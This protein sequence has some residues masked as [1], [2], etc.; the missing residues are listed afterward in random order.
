MPGRKTL[1]WIGYALAVLNVLVLVRL[2]GLAHFDAQQTVVGV[3]GTVIAGIRAAAGIHMMPWIWLARAAERRS[4]L[5]ILI[6]V[7][8]MLVV[9]YKSV[10]TPY[11]EMFGISRERPYCSEGSIPCGKTRYKGLPSG[12]AIVMVSY[13]LNGDDPFV[14]RLVVFVSVTAATLI[15][16]YH[17]GPQYCA[18]ISVELALQVLLFG[19]QYIAKMGCKWIVG[20][21]G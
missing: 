19:T 9:T 13:L 14:T 16:G 2:Y 7:F 1:I 21:F 18:G 5:P 15:G 12:H 4:L 17:S 11:F 3:I 8:T 6:Y 20:Y 10:S